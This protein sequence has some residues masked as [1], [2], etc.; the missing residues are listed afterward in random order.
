MAWDQIHCASTGWKA[1]FPKLAYFRKPMEPYMDPRVC[2]RPTTCG[3]IVATGLT[4][5]T[6]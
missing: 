1:L 3:K 2:Q 6:K 5:L 4:K